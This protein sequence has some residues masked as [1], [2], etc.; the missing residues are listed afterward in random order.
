L[1]PDALPHRLAS[2]PGRDACRARQRGRLQPAR[3]LHQRP[4]RAAAG[5]VGLVGGPAGAPGEE[6]RVGRGHGSRQESAHERIHDVHG[7][8]NGL[9]LPDDDGRDDAVA[10]D[11]GALLRQ[12]HFRAARE[13]GDGLAHPQQDRLRAGQP[14]RDRTRRVQGAHDGP[15][16]QHAVRLARV[17]RPGGARAVL[18]R[19]RLLYL[20]FGL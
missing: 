17:R 16:S 15:A 2:G 18:V 1:S 19:N 8:K 3:I 6:A 4:C 14:G 13:R 11:E 7:G 10:A 12:R 20:I 5:G 9:H